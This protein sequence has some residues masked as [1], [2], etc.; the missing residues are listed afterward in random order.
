VLATLKLS[1][2]I[3][4]RGLIRVIIMS[5]LYFGGVVLFERFTS[6]R[7]MSLPAEGSLLNWLLTTSTLAS[8]FCEEILFRGFV[9]TR[10]RGWMGF[11]RADVLTAVLFS[12]IHWP[13][14]LW[15]N[16][17]QVSLIVEAV[18]IVILAVFL[19]WVVKR[20]GS[21]WPAVAVHEFNNVLSGLL[22]G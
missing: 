8:T 16:G 22:R 3:D 20:T 10:L 19:G 9:L 5:V 1:T 17:F 6:G 14:W 13:H 15:V 4:R 11:W 12:A 2:S 21:L 18:A 7:R